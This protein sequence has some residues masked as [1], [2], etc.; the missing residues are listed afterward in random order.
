MTKAVVANRWVR[1]ALRRLGRLLVSVWV[2]VTAAF[3]I[4]HLI[5]G[6]PVRAA[7]GIN[8][9][10][11]VVEARRE[12][13]GLN[14]PLWE[15]YYRFFTGLFKGDLGTSIMTQLPVGRTIATQLPATLSLAVPAFVVTLLIAI[16]LGVGMAVITRNGR[17]R[18]TE[19]G[20]VGSSVVLGTIPDF[21]YGCM[22][23]ALFGVGLRWL[24][25][26]GRLG[27]NSYIL[28]TAALAI[29]PIVVLS[30]IVRVEVLSVLRT[31]YVRTARAKRLPSWRIYLRHA[32]PN[33]ITATL[34]LSGMLLAGMC[35]STVFVENVFAWPGLGQ[36]IV[37]SITSKDYPVAQGIIMVYALAVIVIN[38]IVDL[39][40]AI[41]DPR[42]TVSEA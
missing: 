30:R 38:T 2:V 33:A 11:A 28:P 24:P 35:V 10:P 16:P 41:I 19:L 36:T 5:P 29:G 27:L 25:V 6:D 7:M 42:S 15:Q 32:L 23:I 40:L 8:V 22:F 20:F 9:S 3:A 1:F 13:L 34:T 37:S 18:R 21:L 17:A 39:I 31:D 26:A 12:A 4:I 14:L